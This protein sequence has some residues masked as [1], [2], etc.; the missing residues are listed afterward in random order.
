[1]NFE[2]TDEHKLIKKTANEFA[3]NE[4]LPGVV[5]RDRKKIWPKEQIKKMSELGFMG[6]MVD[7]QHNGGGMDTISYTIVME[8]IARVDASASVIMSV[9]NSLV[10]S[11]LNKYGSDFQKNKYLKKLSTG[12]NLGAF[13]LSEPQSGSDASNMLTY[14]EKKQK[15]K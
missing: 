3:V 6:M 12:E 11:I 10:C 4:L 5:D 13:S 15:I 14:A 8:E 9:N 2:L 1:M 7:E